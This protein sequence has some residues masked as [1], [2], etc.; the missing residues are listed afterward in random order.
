MTTYITG[1]EVRIAGKQG[2]Y[3]VTASYPVQDQYYYSLNAFDGYLIREDKLLPTGD[4]IL[5]KAIIWEQMQAHIKP[6][7]NI[8]SYHT[9]ITPCQAHSISCEGMMLRVPDEVFVS[10]LSN[11]YL[12][13]LRDAYQAVCGW[14][15]EIDFVL[16]GC[17]DEEK[18]TL[19]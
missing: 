18:T 6:R 10:W 1:Q 8:R 9:W 3:R 4:E 12:P 15:G 11:M 7:L 19:D 5:D 2:A 13:M 16:E 14:P 17:Q